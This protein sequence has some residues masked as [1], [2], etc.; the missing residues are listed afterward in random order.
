MGGPQLD[1]AARESDPDLFNGGQDPAPIRVALGWRALVAAL[2]EMAQQQVAEE[3]ADV[4]AHGSHDREFRV[5]HLGVV[6]S[7][8]DRARVQVAVQQRL[9]LAQ[10]LE[11]QAGHGALESA[12][13]RISAATSSSC[14]L[15]Q[16]LRLADHVGIGEDQVLG[17]LAQLECCRRTSPPARASRRPAA[18]CPT[19]GTAWTRDTRRC[20]QRTADR[21]RRRSCR[22]A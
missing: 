3:L 5:D 2:A 15:V 4:E 10:E 16:R 17:D 9:G 6:C 21:P 1:E 8:H 12:S 22:A 11:L 13:P 18:P 19:C 7:H 14:G 20:A